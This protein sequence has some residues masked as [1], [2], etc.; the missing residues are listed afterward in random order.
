[1]KRTIVWRLII[2]ISVLAVT[3]SAF[4]VHDKPPIGLPYTGRG[5]DYAIGTPPSFV[6]LFD[7]D[8]STPFYSAYKFLPGQAAD[9]GKYPRPQGVKWNDPPGT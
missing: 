2:V 3:E 4:F 5:I 7:P 1:M 6:S 8:T 9:I